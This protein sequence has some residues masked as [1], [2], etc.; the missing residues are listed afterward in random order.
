VCDQESVD[1]LL[2]NV[3]VSTRTAE[4]ARLGDVDQLGGGW[5]EVEDALIHKTIVQDHVCLLEQLLTA[6]REQARVTRTRAHEIDRH[7]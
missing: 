3:A 5:R 4:A 6:H 7:L 1:F 2:G